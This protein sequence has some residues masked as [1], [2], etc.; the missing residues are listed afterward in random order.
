VK[1]TGR[2][3]V[4]GAE[5]DDE[6]AVAGGGCERADLLPVDPD[7][8]TARRDILICLGA[9][10]GLELTLPCSRERCH[11]GNTSL[12]LGTAL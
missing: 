11:S 2:E 4:V 8:R 10:R 9:G 7:T 3:A 5:A 12:R 1:V 6:I